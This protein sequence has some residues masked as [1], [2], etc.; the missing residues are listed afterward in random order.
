MKLQDTQSGQEKELE[1][2]GNVR[3][4]LC[5]VTVYDESHIGLMM[6]LTLTSKHT[7]IKKINP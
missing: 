2:T 5:G 6:A 1:A 3:I 7:L 4:Y